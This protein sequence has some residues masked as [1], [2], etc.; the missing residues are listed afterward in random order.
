MKAEHLEPFVSAAF[1]V[2]Q[3]LTGDMPKR[4]QLSLRNTTFTSDQ[5]TIMAGV[6]GEIEGMAIFGMSTETV[7]QI[8]SAMMGTQVE[9][10][11]EMSLS[12]ISELGNMIAG[13]AATLISQKGFDV[14][15]TPPSVV[16]GENI[17]VSTRVPALVVPMITQFGRVDINVA[18]AENTAA[19]NKAA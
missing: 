9:A 16:R 11:D 4:G 3:M 8:A 1:S 19:R 18:L 13:N 14:D 6:N 2:M 10:L 15:I 17:K 7:I 12:A 5:V